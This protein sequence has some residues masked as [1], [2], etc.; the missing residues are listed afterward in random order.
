MNGNQLT[1]KQ[2]KKNKHLL[3]IRLSAMGDCAMAVPVLLNFVKTYPEVKITVLTKPFFVPIFE[4]IPNVSVIPAETKQEHKGFFGLLKLAFQLKKTGINEVADLHNVL[5]SKI[6]RAFF[7][8]FGI[9]SAAIDKGR[10]EKKA[11]TR[12]KYKVFKPLKTS[13]ERYADV[14]QKLGYPVDLSEEMSLKKPA[15]NKK[16]NTIIGTENK[17]WIGIAPFAAHDSKTY[18]LDLME[19][20]IAELDKTNMYKLLFF[21]G[22]KKEN[23]LL[24]NLASKYENGISLVGKLEFNEELQLIANLDLMLSMDSGNGHLAAMFG[25]PVITLW[26]ATHPFA[27]FAPFGQP[28]ENQLLPNLKKYPLLPT[29]VYGKTQIPGYEDVMRSISPKRVLER[30]KKAVENPLSKKG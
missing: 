30:V 6:L 11:L 7:F 8:F 5:R 28:K 15:L 27:G 26:G 14:F 12:E 10:Q 1:V 9:K 18:P 25:I 17:K 20:V 21:G 2:D 23:D 4:L 24:N 19:T 22:G 13:P 16:L 29:S 3:V